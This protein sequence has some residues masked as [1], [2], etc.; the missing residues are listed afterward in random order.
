MYHYSAKVTS[1][2]DGDTFRA[3]VDLGFH[4]G[5]QNLAFRMADIDAPELRGASLVKGRAARDYMREMILGKDIEIKT[6]KDKS[7]KYG[8]WIADVYV[9]NIHLNAAIVDEGH[10]AKRNYD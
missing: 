6:Q 1:V 4:V 2:Y 9:G 5:C 7:G 8:R 3:D 10:A